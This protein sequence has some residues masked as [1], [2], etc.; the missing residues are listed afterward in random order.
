MKFHCK[1]WKAPE[2]YVPTFL[3]R[4]PSVGMGNNNHNGISNSHTHIS[5]WKW[6][7]YGFMWLHNKKYLYTGR[8]AQHRVCSLSSQ[9]PWHLHITH[10]HMTS[11]CIAFWAC[12]YSCFRC[13]AWCTWYRIDVHGTVCYSWYLF[14]FF[15]RFIFFFIIYFVVKYIFIDWIKIG[16]EWV[17]VVSTTIETTNWHKWNSQ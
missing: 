2:F 7:L 15:S 4:L 17:Y 6:Y 8:K 14:I 16:A 5:R 1:N 3:A 12:T 13:I 10:P 9:A 11:D